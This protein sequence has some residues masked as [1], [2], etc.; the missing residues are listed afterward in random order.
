MSE[1]PTEFGTVTSAG[2]IPTQET[3]TYPA[4]TL[5]TRFSL[6]RVS[7]P[8]SERFL[9]GQLTCDMK[10]I[11]DTVWQAGACCNAKGRMIANFIMVRDGDDFIL[12]LPAGQDQLLIE[13]LKKYAV[14]FKAT[15]TTADELRIVGEIPAEITQ[16]ERSVSKLNDALILTWED[17]RREFWVA[18]EEVANTLNATESTPSAPSPRPEGALC[19][20]SRWQL[21]DF[22]AG[23][24]WVRPESSGAWVPQ[25]CDWQMHEGISFSKGCY[26]G[27][28]VVA[29]LQYL[30][31]SKR[32]LYA[33][34]SNEPLPPLM[35]EIAINGKNKGEVAD[36]FMNR[37][38]AVVSADDETL[39]AEVDTQT[40][41]LRRVF[42]TQE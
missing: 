16:H 26:T 37:G 31:K 17:G 38:L 18:P 11:S 7:G 10:T 28:E 13:H 8:D 41:T 32:H 42:Y 36:G 5:L 29:R 24:L 1:E 12:R 39:S 40:M 25:Y 2:F 15:M 19:A 30:G 20:E 6:I 4:R 9:Q 33:I 23:W 35:T 21:A 14:F 22:N 27:Q 34:E 3:S